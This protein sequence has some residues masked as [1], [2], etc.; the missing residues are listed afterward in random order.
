MASGCPKFFFSGSNHVY[1]VISSRARGL[2]V[3]LNLNADQYCNFDCCYCE[4]DRRSLPRVH[5][6]APVNAHALAGELANALA[7]VNAGMLTKHPYFASLSADMLKLAHVA[8]S[9]EGEPT[10]CPNFSEAV[11]SVVHLRAAGLAPFFKLVLVTNATALDQPAVRS[12]LRLFT[13]SDEV[14]AKLDVGSQES[15]DRI[16]RS[17]VPL[18]KVLE[19]ILTLGRNRP[20]VIQSM[21]VELDGLLPDRVELA[22]YAQR[23]TDLKT[24][25][26]QISLVQVYSATRPHHS[27]RC[28]HL[29]LRVLSDIAA[30]VHQATGLRVEVF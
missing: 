3:G 30:Q 8:I 12:G 13:R 10:L 16:N 18:D 15:M 29:S 23:L 19:N 7:F 9:G 6:P 25:G 11:E 20:V 1:A 26:A 4:V 24:S 22:Q 2:A 14:W 27:R 5:G 28:K 21:F 17:S